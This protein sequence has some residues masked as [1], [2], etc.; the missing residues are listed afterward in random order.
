MSGI[1]KV[2]LLLAAL[3]CISKAQLN[4]SKQSCLCRSVR[5]SIMK[6][7]R[8]RDIQIYPA[9]MFCNKVEIVVTTSNGRRYCL[10]PD[11]K[12]VQD[13]V[14]DMINKKTPTVRRA[15]STS[16]PSSNPDS[17]STAHN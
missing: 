14:L 11:K 10:N 6:N 2:F 1:I 16:S 15:Q 8:Q 3:I 12:A 9:T 4:E 5:D 7:S 17:S 13:L